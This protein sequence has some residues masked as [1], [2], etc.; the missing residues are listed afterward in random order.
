M[1]NNGIISFSNYRCAEG[2]FGNPMEIGSK[3]I[4]CDCNGNP[5]NPSTG[6]CLSCEG[7]SE[8]WYC[9][10]CKI[11]YFGNPENKNCSSKTFYY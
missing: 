9:E 6:Q 4:P 3:C 10:R 1:R 5:C 11:G 7:N 8:G 2:Y